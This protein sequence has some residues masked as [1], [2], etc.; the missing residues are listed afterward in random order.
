MQASTDIF[1]L[2][3]AFLS[4]LHVPDTPSSRYTCPGR[5]AHTT[6][7]LLAQLSAFYGHALCTRSRLYH[8][9]QIV[10]N[11][12]FDILMACLTVLFCGDFAPF[13]LRSDGPPPD[14]SSVERWRSGGLRRTMY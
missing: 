2:N 7:C 1:C 8:G 11:G 10:S 12:E 4:S 5:E 9:Q 13:V 6:F 14:E 3:F